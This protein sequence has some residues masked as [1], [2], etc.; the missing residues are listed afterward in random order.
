MERGARLDGE[1]RLLQVSDV[2]RAIEDQFHTAFP[3]RIWVFGSLRG[4]RST[5]YVGTDDAG[6]VNTP[7]LTGDAFMLVED[8]EHGMRTL[9]CELGPEPRLAIDDSLRRL[10]D[11]AV[12]DLLV[13]GHY[14]RVGGLLSY[15]PDRHCAIFEVTALDPGPTAAWLADRREQVRT[16]ASSARLAE[17]QRDLRVPAAPSSVAL[18]AP[19]GDPALQRAQEQLAGCGFA[20]D[21]KVY[22]PEVAGSA[23]GDQL[24][25]GLREAAL[26]GH[27][28]V[29]LL[30]QD[31]RPLSL[32]PYDS[33][34]VVRAIA[35]SGVPILTG[36]GSPDEAAAAEEVAHQ[37]YPTADEATASVIRRLER[38]SSDLEDSVREVAQAG[39]NALRRAA[40]HLEETRLNLAEDFRAAHQRAAR[41]RARRLLR[42]RL[43]ALVLALAIVAAA[44]LTMVWLILAAL[45]IPAAIAL[46][47]PRLRPQR[48]STLTVTEYSFADAV[49][50]L[51]DIGR[52]LGDVAD[53]DDVVRLEGEADALAEHCRT[54]LRRPRVL[55]TATG[56]SGSPAAAPAR[57]AYPSVGADGSVIGVPDEPPTRPGAVVD[58]R[59]P[60]VTLPA[61]Q[62]LATIDVTKEQSRT[63]VLPSDPAPTE[64]R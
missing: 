34:A 37:G 35:G 56:S 8:T 5:E 52:Q 23:A 31:G 13:E 12:D 19:A 18:V 30:R 10:H 15:D 39:G 26:A 59:N 45:V 43:V 57:Q 33:E 16:A 48:R 21:V 61:D 62:P 22:A 36:L 63:V 25:N 60:M 51:K 42:I 20:I 2:L 3:R 27:D 38:A 46:A 4:L 24:A 54:L 1:R 44:V 41:I 9:L 17:R 11:V 32:A 28:L 40:R 50:K 58:A 14:I 7:E 6:A 53:P 55:R 49:A 64:R 29:L 47:A